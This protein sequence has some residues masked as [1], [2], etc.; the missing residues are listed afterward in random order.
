MNYE[1][2]AQCIRSGQLS[3]AQIAEHMKDEVFAAWYGKR[4]PIT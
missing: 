1:L 3:A 4:Y 2:L